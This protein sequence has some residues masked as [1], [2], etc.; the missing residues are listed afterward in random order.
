MVASVAESSPASMVAILR[1][2]GF[3]PVVDVTLTA[4][5]SAS[6]THIASVPPRPPCSSESSPCSSCQSPQPSAERVRTSTKSPSGAVVPS[7]VTP[8]SPKSAVR[9]AGN[10]ATSSPSG[11]C[12]LASPCP[13]SPRTSS[14]FAAGSAS[15][16]ASC[17]TSTEGGCSRVDSC[18]TTS[19]APVDTTGVAKPIDAITVRATATGAV[20]Q[21]ECQESMGE[22]QSC[23][24][25]YSCGCSELLSNYVHK[26]TQNATL[27]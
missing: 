24:W 22:V 15:G 1:S 6:P 12:E 5:P 3:S 4:T 11:P 26:I 19:A 9:V 20:L 18:T 13:S 2:A 27:F 17:F 7:Q 14:A 16:T 23:Y 21:N 10:S 25:C 8:T